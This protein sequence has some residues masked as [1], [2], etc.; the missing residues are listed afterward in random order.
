MIDKAMEHPAEGSPTAATAVIPPPAVTTAPAPQPAPQ[1]TVPASHGS[2]P[3]GAALGARALVPDGGEETPLLARRRQGW[4]LGLPPYADARKRRPPLII[5]V[6]GGKGGVG[7]SLVSANLAMKLAQ[8][9][10]RVVAVDLDIG[11]ANLHTYFGVHAPKATL[12]DAIVYRHKSFAEV[13]TPTGIEG[14]SIVA[15]GREEIWGGTGALDRGVLRTL[16]DALLGVKERGEADV[17]LLDLGAGTHRHT[18]DFFNSAHVGLITVLPEPTSIENAYLF[19]K[20]ALFRVIE[21]VGVKLGATD[22]ADEIRATLL[23][24][25]AGGEGGARSRAFGYAEKLRQIGAYYPGFVGQVA[26]ALT[27]R[28]LGITVN[29]VRS[30]QD[31]DV[32]KSMELIGERYFGYQTRFCGYLNYDE[33]AWKSLRNRRLLTVDFPHSLIARRFSELSRAVL[34]NLGF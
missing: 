8:T 5:A 24:A 29:Q 18:L 34:T 14:V 22:T 1:P 15:G 9:G 11:G 27:G 7:K 30:Q 26:L 20:T 19:L 10:R 23:A 6:G 12:S 28:T 4:E 31:I 17:V 13:M 25:D 21:N 3:Y 16:F 32:G 2:L 33:A